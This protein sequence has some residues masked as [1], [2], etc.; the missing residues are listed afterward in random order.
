MC[1][2]AC[3]CWDG[4][5]GEGVMGRDGGVLGFWRE[6]GVVGRGGHFGC[7]TMAPL[8]DGDPLVFMNEPSTPLPPHPPGGVVCLL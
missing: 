7:E 5:G 2:R 8:R 3:V 1:S 4:G 6:E